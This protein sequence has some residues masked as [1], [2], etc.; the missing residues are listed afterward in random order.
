MSRFDEM[1]HPPHAVDDNTADCRLQAFI[2]R[3]LLVQHEVLAH[4]GS[5]RVA[6]VGQTLNVKEG[7]RVCRAPYNRTGGSCPGPH[8]DHDHTRRILIMLSRT[9]LT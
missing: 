8:S 6:I 4:F 2:E 3:V 7:S 9:Q 5:G 1:S